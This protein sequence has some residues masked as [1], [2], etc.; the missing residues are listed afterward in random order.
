[1][2]LKFYELSDDISASWIATRV[3]RIGNSRR[4][5][6]Q[7]ELGYIDGGSQVLVDALVDAYTEKGGR[8]HLGAA[9]ERIEC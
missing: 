2:E 4:S 5:I 9:A 6:F 7:E 8:L 1:M 3:R